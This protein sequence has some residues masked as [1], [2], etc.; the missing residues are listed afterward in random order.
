[1]EFWTVLIITYGGFLQGNVSYV[2][3]PSQEACE[4]QMEASYE[5]LHPLM[6]DVMLQCQETLTPSNMVRPKPRPSWLK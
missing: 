1:M 4:M 3:T 2:A 6:P 5:M